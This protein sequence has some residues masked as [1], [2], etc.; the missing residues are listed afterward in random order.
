MSCVITIIFFRL[1]ISSQKQIQKQNNVSVGLK[2]GRDR[3]GSSDES[4]RSRSRSRSVVSWRVRLPVVLSNMFAPPRRPKAGET[5]QDLLREQQ[6]FQQQHGQNERGQAEEEEVKQHEVSREGEEESLI[7]SVLKG[8]KIVERNAAMTAPA[9]A[10]SSQDAGT[11]SFPP[12]FQVNEDHGDDG[13]KGKGKKSL[14]ARMARNNKEK[15]GAQR[16]KRTDADTAETNRQPVS[17]MMDFGAS[18]SIVDGSGLEGGQ[19]QARDIHEENAARIAA[20]TEEEILESRRQLMS[21]MDPSLVAFLKSKRTA[22]P[23]VTTTN[24]PELASVAD[25]QVVAPKKPRLQGLHMDRSEP[26]KMEWTKDVPAPPPRED[27][28]SGYSARFDFDGR[29]LPFGYGEEEHDAPPD[30]GSGLYHHGEEPNR[31]GYSVEELLTLA[32]STNAQ[33][34]VLALNSLA[35]IVRNFKGGS[36]DRCLQQNLLAELLQNDLLILLRY[37]LIKL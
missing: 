20:M 6:Q 17:D 25:G 7:Q 8:G 24:A 14:F 30:S 37:S 21:S 2:K 35:A 4:N 13:K 1:K 28:R 10:P 9:K 29:L 16:M 27:L 11:T 19:K 36:L 23:T 3:T 5:E 26:E 18:S 32:R 22:K 34:K 15:S 31:P 12:V 33:Q